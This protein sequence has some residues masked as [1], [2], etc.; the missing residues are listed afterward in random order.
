LQAPTLTKGSGSSGTT[1]SDS[2]SESAIPEE[3]QQYDKAIVQKIMSDIVSRGQAVTFDDISG[4]EFAK[5]CV[6]ELIC[7]WVLLL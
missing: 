2:S 1:S 3:L 5:K 6:Q 4:L 7:W